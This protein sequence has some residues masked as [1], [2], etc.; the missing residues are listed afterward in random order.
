MNENNQQQLACQT[1]NYR[2]VSQISKIKRKQFKRF[3]L[4]VNIN[5]LILRTLVFVNIKI[6][7]IFFL[8]QIK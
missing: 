3:I 4:I 1:T 5:K 8:N 2:F 6:I 7:Q